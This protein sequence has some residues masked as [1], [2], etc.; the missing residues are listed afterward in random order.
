MA[1][2]KVA[3]NKRESN[4]SNCVGYILGV[5]FLEQLETKSARCKVDLN[6][7][8]S[9]VFNKNFAPKNS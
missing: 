8:K 1:K 9:K 7:L 2:W 6:I 5:L 4:L 3:P